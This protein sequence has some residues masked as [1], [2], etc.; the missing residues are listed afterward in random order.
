[1]VAVNERALAF[2]RTCFYPGGGG[3]PSDDGTVRVGDG[4]TLAIVSARAGADEIVWHLT[5]SVLS[6]DL[7]GRPATLTV[8]APKRLALTRHHTVLHVL[9]TIALRDYGGWI[10][11]VQ[12]GT[13][14]GSTSSWTACLPRSARSSRPR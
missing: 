9:N 11:G 5:P 14:R 2:D 6:P 1:V 13:N 10:T 4:E 8:N 3:Q 12:I 7:V